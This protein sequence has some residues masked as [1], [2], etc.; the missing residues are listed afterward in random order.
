[1]KGEGCRY[2]C[3]PQPLTSV[4]LNWK[5]YCQMR[6][7]FLCLLSLGENLG[8]V[9]MG[10]FCADTT[11]SFRELRIPE[12]RQIFMLLTQR[13]HAHN[14][15]V[16]FLNRAQ[17]TAKFS[18]PFCKQNARLVVEKVIKNAR[19]YNNNKKVK[20]ETV[21]LLRYCSENFLISTDLPFFSA[22]PH[23]FLQFQQAPNSESSFSALLL[24]SPTMLSSLP[25]TLCAVLMEASVPEHI[26]CLN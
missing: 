21:N 15:L 20:Q 13:F 11:W 24:G 26:H 23:Q 16:H 3:I 14:Q 6:C 12:L 18:L 17:L 2:I 10:F 5:R 19:K 7:L 4:S 8:S 25:H 22:Y 9:F 1:M